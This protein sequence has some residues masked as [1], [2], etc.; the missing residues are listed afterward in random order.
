MLEWLSG[1]RSVR[2][3]A[4]RSIER[5]VLERVVLAATTAPS[6]TNR[7][8]WRFTV[9]TD[10]ARRAAMVAAVEAET[11][12]NKAIIAR[13][14]H[15]EEFGRYGDF[16]HEPLATAPA[17]IVPQYRP[18]PDQ[19]AHFIQ[20]G[21]GDPNAFVT[22]AAMQMELC[23]ASAAIMLLLLQARAEGLGA[24]WMAGPT[25]ARAAI[26]EICEIRP[27]Y[28]MLGA[29]VLGYAAEDPPRTERR[30]LERSVTWLEGEGE[31]AAG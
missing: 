31:D 20:S 16:F 6:S 12:A 14:H 9:V 18:Y 7:Q 23:G 3:F 15:A 24:C 8:P 4:D 25:V 29:V 17:I 28:Q 30:P 11:N 5:R 26:H 19:L 13:G 21:G 1:R 27:P 22:P 10:P 2:R